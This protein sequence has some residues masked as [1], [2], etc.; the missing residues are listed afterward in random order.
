MK[1][2]AYLFLILFSILANVLPAGDTKPSPVK[3]EILSEN[4]T[5]QPGHPF[6]VAVKF[7]LKPDW[8]VYWKNPGD[9]GMP[10]K[11]EWILPSHMEVFSEEWPTPQRFGTE[12]L[13]GFGYADEA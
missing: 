7:K 3:V 8:H 5:I 1:V 12:G 9:A 6:W 11:I 13:T 10:L 4:E 2:K